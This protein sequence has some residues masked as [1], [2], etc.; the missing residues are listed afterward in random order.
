MPR[1]RPKKKEDWQIKMEE[2]LKSNQ[3][4]LDM[5][6][7]HQR[8][9]IKEVMLSIDNIMDSYRSL[10]HPGYQDIV[11]LDDAFW[12]LKAAFEIVANVPIPI[13]FRNFRRVIF[14]FPPIAIEK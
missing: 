2:R 9:S 11:R 4:L 7:D 13:V 5:M 12:K 10:T 8:E 1:G 6:N 14:I 3:K